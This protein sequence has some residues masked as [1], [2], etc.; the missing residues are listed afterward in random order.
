MTRAI[1]LIT[2]TVL[3]ACTQSGP[4]GSI[5]DADLQGSCEALV[6][7]E[8]GTRPSDVSAVSTQTEPSGSVTTISVAGA[9]APWLCYADF[10]GVITG[11]EYSQ[12]G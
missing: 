4:G 8:T 1:F 12:E 3:S 2:A 11:V 5:N 6:V 10:A 9:A 7:A